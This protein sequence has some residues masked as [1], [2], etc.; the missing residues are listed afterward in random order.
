MLT[1]LNLPVAI[2][3]HKFQPGTSFFIPCINRLPVQKYIARE[4]RRLGL[5]V[6]TKCVVEN[7][8]YGVRVWRNKDTIDPHSLSY[9][10]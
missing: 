5:E 3:W 8:V 2:E 7:Y 6:T 9:S 1:I 10:P 4:A